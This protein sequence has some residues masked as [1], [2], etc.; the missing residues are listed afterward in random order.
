MKLVFKVLVFGLM[1]I[2]ITASVVPGTSGTPLPQTKIDPQVVSKLAQILEHSGYTYRKAADNVWVVTFKG[3]SK[4]D[5]QVFVTSAENLIVMGTVVATK[6][7]MK[8]TPELMF[9]LLRIVHDIDRVKIGFDD[10]E[11]LFLRAEVTNKCFD[12]DAF[13]STMDQISAG[14]DK[15]YAAIKAH[16][17]P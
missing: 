17:V 15:V 13:K 4:A 11:D 1:A 3:K 6:A 12:V 5:I 8:V 14:T 16:L 9:K 10:D 7:S 2:T